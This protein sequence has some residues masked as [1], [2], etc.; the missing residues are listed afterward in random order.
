MKPKLL[1][2]IIVILCLSL[3][4]SGQ[5]IESK[6]NSVIAPSEKAMEEVVGRILIYNFKPA[7]RPSTIYLS[8]EGITESWLPPIKNIE[9]QLL[10]DEAIQDREQGVYFFTKPQSSKEKYD[11]SFAFGDPDCKYFGDEWRFYESENKVK[12]WRV[13]EILGFC[14]GSTEHIIPIQLNI[15]PNELEGYQ[16]FGKGRLEALS[17]TVSTKED[18]KQAFGEQCE[19]SC[20]YDPNWRIHFNYFGN[21]TKEITVINVSKKYVSDAQYKGKLYSIRLTP[22]RKVLFDKII[23]PSQFKKAGSY[24]AGHDGMG[25]GTNSSHEIYTD[26]YGLEYTIL[27]QID[28]TTKKNLSWRKGELTSIGYTIPD[29]LEEKMFIEQK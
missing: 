15:Y 17:L 5:G 25:G 13:V 11:I 27:D 16:F 20:D 23:F 14:S 2:A 21:L 4:A 19:T 22:K 18:V 1:S 6:N 29:K 7:N 24:S 3:F 10:S 8:R 26:S 28:L 12:L 9:F